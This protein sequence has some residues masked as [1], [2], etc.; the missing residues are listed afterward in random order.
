MITLNVFFDVKEESKQEYLALLN[1]MVVQSN[2]EEGCSY[3]HL[4]EDKT[5]A[6]RFTLVEHWDSQE[7]LEEHNKTSHWIQFND[8][9]NNYLVTPY[10]EHHY[11]EI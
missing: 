1:H 7:S 3:Y 10:E 8:T 5:Q 9:V 4:L 2:K 11:A 6:G